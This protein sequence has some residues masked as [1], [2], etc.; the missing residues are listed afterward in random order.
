[1][2]RHTPEEL[3]R[4]F[5]EF[6]G[7]GLWIPLPQGG[8]E[9]EVGPLAMVYIRWSEVAPNAATLEEGYW[10][11]LQD[12][13][14]WGALGVLAL[15]N[16]ILVVGGLD[17][18][19]H[20]ILN[21]RFLSDELKA[22]VAEYKLEQSPPPARRAVPVVFNRLG[23]LLLMRHLILY[24]PDLG[25]NIDAPVENVGELA[26]FANEFAQRDTLPTALGGSGSELPLQFVPIWDIYNPGDLAYALPRMFTVLTEILPGP[27]SE[28]R[29]LTAKLGMDPSSLTISGIGLVDLISVVFGLYALGNK[30]REVGKDAVLFDYKRAFEKAPAI[31]PAAETF[32]SERSLT[33]A[34][35]KARFEAEIPGSRKAFSNEIKERS[36][37]ASG[38]DTLR[39][40]P[41]LKLDDNRTLILDLQFLVNLVTSGVYWTIF[42]NLPRSRRE[43]F[44]QLWGRLLELYATDLLQEFYPAVSGLL[45]ADVV[46]R[47]GQIDALLDF[48]NNVIVFEVKSSLLSEAAKRLGNRA[49]FEK[50]VNLKFV[51]N[52]KGKPKAVLQLA[53]SA[54]S[55]AGGLVPTTAKPARITRF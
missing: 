33:L 28:V 44:Q 23:C 2:K 27:D 21:Q 18:Q 14:R 37:L 29:K 46:Y 19:V 34:E 43:T 15:I 22:K 13:P 24:G 35:F 26:L 50:Q 4:I 12:V 47:G 25:G 51:R 40:F 3:G 39:K 53:K 6:A 36:F 32:L 11:T 54:R 16:N 20:R 41:L 52:E 48:A 55:I 45:K 38:L 10:D 49:E 8:A 17:S 30:V 5:Q 7:K 9:I 42:D 1:M 31:L